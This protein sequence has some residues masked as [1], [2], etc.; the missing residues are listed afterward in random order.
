MTETARYSAVR[1]AIDL[2]ERL[3][4]ATAGDRKLTL[5]HDEVRQFIG[6]ETDPGLRQRRAA[7]RHAMRHGDGFSA[8]ILERMQSMT[9]EQLQN[10]IRTDVRMG[11][12]VAEYLRETGREVPAGVPKRHGSKLTSAEDDANA[13]RIAK[14]PLWDGIIAERKVEIK[15]ATDR[16]NEKMKIKEAAKRRRSKKPVT[17]ATAP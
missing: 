9:A 12:L 16:F 14:N 3:V 11:P 13:E 15:R 10:V 17:Q 2:L 7:L 6:A 5:L 4:K 1:V 8:I